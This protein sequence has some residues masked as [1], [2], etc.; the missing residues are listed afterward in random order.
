MHEARGAESSTRPQPRASRSVR[1]TP[2]IV[3]ARGD[4][5]AI[6]GQLAKAERIR[7]RQIDVEVHEV[8]GDGWVAIGIVTRGLVVEEGLRFEARAGRAD[9]AERRLKMD[10]EAALV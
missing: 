8:P 4:G 10:I 9:E 5:R 6:G 2:C 1:N 3:G 7:G